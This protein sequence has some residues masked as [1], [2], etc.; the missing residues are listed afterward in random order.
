M[1]LQ[2]L[3]TYFSGGTNGR[4]FYD[5]HLICQTIELPWK[6]NQRRVS[7]I[8]EGKYRLTKRYS[9]KF[10]WHLE[11]MEVKNRSL[12]LLH[13]ANNAAKEL[14]GCIAPVTHISGAGM[15]TLSAIAF[16]KLKDMVYKA[17]DGNEAVWLKITS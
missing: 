9:S 1:E 4:L 14:M 2:I 17:I 7:C 8:P 10:G 5:G 11:I 15:G 6:E 16:K 12:I 3:R 13:P